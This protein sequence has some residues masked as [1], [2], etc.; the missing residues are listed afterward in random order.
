MVQAFPGL[1]VVNV[2]NDILNLRIIKDEEEIQK[3]TQAFD[4]GPI[5]LDA[6]EG[7]ELLPFCQ[8]RSGQASGRG[9]A[10]VR[11][12]TELKTGFM[13]VPLAIAEVQGLT[14]PDKFVL[15][16]GH[17]DSWHRGASDNGTANACMLETARVLGKHRNGLHR[18]VR[19]AWW[20][21]HSQGR[22]SGST[23]YVDHHW[24]DLHRHAIVHLNVD[25][26]G[27]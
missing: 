11:L 5:Q 7:L 20:S 16:N 3:V 26:L 18:G 12:T 15:F 17:I 10:K 22:Y 27:C 8:S 4:L 14:E 13:K 23:W 1:K 19:F 25:S 9:P 6:P 24:I 2:Q 21:G